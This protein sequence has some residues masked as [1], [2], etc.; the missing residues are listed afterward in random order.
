MKTIAIACLTAL[1][2][3]AS[4]AAE[5]RYETVFE[6]SFVDNRHGWRQDVNRFVTKKIAN[7][8][9]VFEHRRRKGRWFALKKIGIDPSRDFQIEADLKKVKGPDEWAYGIVWGGSIESDSYYFFGIRGTGLCF[10]GKKTREGWRQLKEWGRHAAVNRFNS[11]NKVAIRKEGTTTRFFVNDAHIG[12]ALFENFFGDL[13]GFKIVRNIGIE[14]HYFLVTQGG[15][16]SVETPAGKEENAD[17]EEKP[18]KK[19][20]LVIGN[21]DYA[22]A[23]LANPVSD[24][25]AMAEAFRR[26]GF[27]ATIHENITQRAMK[28]AVDGFGQRLKGCDAGLFFYSGHGIQ[29]KG[30]NYLM[31]VDAN[32]STE[33]EVEYECV[34]A[35]R[36]LAEMEGAG[37]AVNIVILDAC[38][39]NPFERGWTRSSAGSGL[40]AMTAPSG[41]LIAYATAPGTVA[42]DDS[43]LDNH[44]PYASSLL[45]HIGTPN[46]SILELFQRVRKDVIEVT[47]D[48]Q[49]PWESTSL[50]DNFY[51]VK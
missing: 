42:F 15:L 13:A 47:G 31:P 46:I 4:A 37:C 25:R 33:S 10:Y 34:N 22:S 5:V 39:N 9:F 19:F 2:F 24:A 18:E 50:T 35:G 11:A 7:G 43:S 29:A 30:Q 36:I 49:I 40:A 1:L 14:I 17:K 44:S 41:T 12:D 26:L 48:R 8:K 21:G 28:E 51:F 38:R 27:D 23:P 32:P 6:D 3:G 45:K 20:A 16:V